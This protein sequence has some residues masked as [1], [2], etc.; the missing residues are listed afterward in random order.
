MNYTQNLINEFGHHYSLNKSGE[1]PAKDI[2][3]VFDRLKEW[4]NN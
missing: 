4:L 3:E 2:E 1:M